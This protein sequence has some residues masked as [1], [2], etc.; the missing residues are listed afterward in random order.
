MA[1]TYTL[2]ALTAADINGIVT[3]GQDGT[4]NI[5]YTNLTANQIQQI[6]SA[7]EVAMQTNLNPIALSGEYNDLIGAPSLPNSAL[8]TVEHEPDEEHPE[9]WTSQEVKKFS[10]VAF[11]G[12]ANDLENDAG[13]LTSFTETDP[14]FSASPA[15]NITNQDITNWNN[16]SDFSGNYEDLNRIPTLATVATSG[17]YND[18]INKPQV[19]ISLEGFTNSNISTEENNKLRFLGNT[20]AYILNYDNFLNSSNMSLKDIF[21]NSINKYL[22]TSINLTI[23][24]TLYNFLVNNIQSYNPD[25]EEAIYYILNLLPINNCNYATIRYD[26]D[27]FNEDIAN[28]Q[29][30]NLTI[31]EQS[32]I[33]IIDTIYNVLYFK[34]K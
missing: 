28:Q 7:F 12:K 6:G 26:L 33:L 11:S 24:S 29:L 17:N 23:K 19:T 18:L 32:F 1:D 8:E 3:A 10:D 16:K 30:S 4:Y 31:T 34:K 22:Q 21:L 27:D 25:G 13:F 2:P 20:D 14:I 5:T 15:A 9:T